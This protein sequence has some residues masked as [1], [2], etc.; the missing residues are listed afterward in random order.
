[1]TA[2]TYT[3]LCTLLTSMTTCSKSDA[4]GMRLLKPQYDRIESMAMI[5]KMIAPAAGSQRTKG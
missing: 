5:V 1:M 3:D 2:T 4:N